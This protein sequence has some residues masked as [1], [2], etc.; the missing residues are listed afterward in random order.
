MSHHGPSCY[1]YQGSRGVDLDVLIKM[2]YPFASLLDET[3]PSRQYPTNQRLLEKF[4]DC[5][6]FYQLYRT[7][8]ASPS[9]LYHMAN[10]GL[11]W[12]I[13][14]LLKKDATLIDARKDESLLAAAIRR[15]NDDTFYLLLA[16]GAKIDENALVCASSRGNKEL[17]R[18]L[19]GQIP[20]ADVWAWCGK[21]AKAACEEGH[22]EI[23]QMILQKCEE[24]NIV[25]CI[26]GDSIC[27]AFKRGHEA[28][29]R[30]LLG[31]PPHEDFYSW[32]LKSASRKGLYELVEMILA[33]DT[34]VDAADR[35]TQALSIA[36]Q[37][38]RTAIVKL[39]L[40]NGAE[41]QKSV[42]HA[43]SLGNEEILQV[44]LANGG[45]PNARY[46][47]ETALQT[48]CF[49][50]HTNT[51]RALLELGASD[52]GLFGPLG[53]AYD[54]AVRGGHKEVLSLLVSCGGTGL[55]IKQKVCPQSS[56]MFYYAWS[57]S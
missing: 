14:T 12:A 6:I 38:G 2:R 16:R 18:L 41:T 42:Y 56:T 35:R 28:M 48:A 57:M 30:V 51:V 43:A 50:G 9:A 46:G 7:S 23:L 15:H 17:F 53:T 45:D 49:K 34:D 32:S 36:C 10:E 1:H 54:S 21:A 31:K 40:K 55:G 52:K 33:R 29:V 24:A 11:T 27:V 22:V 19:I 20:D 47:G 26:K 3:R 37:N 5:D 13:E 8:T 39:L 44:L 25:C 4:T